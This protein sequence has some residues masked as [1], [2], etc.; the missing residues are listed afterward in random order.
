MATVTSVVSGSN[1]VY[2]ITDQESNVITVTAPPPGQSVTFS[3]NGMN[4]AQAALAN[5]LN[6][7]VANGTSPRPQVLTNASSSYF[8]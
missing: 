4:D 2:T 7:L 6:M 8:S 5:L 3:G 1:V